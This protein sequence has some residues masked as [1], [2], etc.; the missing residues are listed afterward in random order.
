M[1]DKSKIIM[2]SFGVLLCGIS[3]R[4]IAQDAISLQQAIAI[5]QN[6]DPW[7]EGNRLHEQATESKSIAANSLPNPKVS[8]AMMNLPTDSWDINQEP[9][10]QFKVG[11]S[12][13]LPRGDALNI[14]QSQLKIE[15]SKFRFLRDDRKAKLAVKVSQ[16]WLDAYLAQ[17]TIALI[18]HDKALFE[19]VV[20]VVKASYASTTGKTRQ[21]DVI[22]SQL[23]LTQLDDRLTLQHQKLDVA[24]ASLSQWV[25]PQANNNTFESVNFGQ[26]PASLAVQNTLPKIS[27][28]QSHWLETGYFSRNELVSILRNHPLIRAIDVKEKVLRKD[29]DLA[30]QQYKPQWEL[31]ASYAVRDDSALGADRADFFS[32]G[33]TFDM[34]IFTQNKQDKLVSSAKARSE[35]TKTEKRLKLKAMMSEVEKELLNLQRLDQRELLYETQ[36]LSQ[37]HE[38]AEAALTAY[39]NDDG[40]FTEVVHARIAELNARISMLN[41]KV[42]EL[43]TIARIN[44]FL[45]QSSSSNATNN[46]AQYDVN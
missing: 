5:A 40:N 6:S 26:L 27:L 42:D 13:V 45:T 31:N 38:Q 35:A 17:E 20:D 25:H 37:T 41:I 22:R 23:E 34:P 12:Q 36:L 3:S 28:I 1:F 2:V 46:G 21:Q 39:T 14:K 32:F 44:Y 33:V 19:Q 8:I 10:T 43:K 24:L 18:N 11:M 30:N 7:L 29:V 16:L 9:M 4:V 15:A